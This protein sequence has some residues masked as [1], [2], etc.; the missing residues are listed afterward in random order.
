MHKTASKIASLA[1]TFFSDR[2]QNQGSA[3]TMVHLFNCA[4]GVILQQARLVLCCFF[5]LV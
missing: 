2:Q 5:L 4:T 1:P 3:F